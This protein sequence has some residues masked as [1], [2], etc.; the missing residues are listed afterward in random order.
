VRVLWIALAIAGAI[1]L[2]STLARFAGGVAATVDLALVAVVATSLLGGPVAGMLSGSGAG[3]VQDALSGGVVGIGGLAKATVG[4]LGGVVALQ[5]DVSAWMP[6][7]VLLFAA[8][9]VHA[10]LFMGA[11][12]LLDL[13]SFPAPVTSVALEGLGN[14]AAGVAL[15]GMVEGVPRM[16]AR[17]RVRRRARL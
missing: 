16:L 2:Q 1:T 10:A 17:R 8:T 13:R 15:F 14:V 7:L 12:T 11:Y 6:R 4:F 9:L 5:F 3:I